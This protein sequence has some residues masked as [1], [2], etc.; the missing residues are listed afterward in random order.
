MSHALRVT[1][2]TAAVVVATALAAPTAL[3]QSESYP[4]PYR[5][6]PNH[7]KMPEGRKLGGTAGID[8]DRDGRSIWAFERCATTTCKGSNV[9]PLLK[10]D[11]SGNVVKSLGAGMFVQP[12]GVY[13][14]AD[15][16][17][18]VTDGDGMPGKGHQVFKLNQDGKVLLT[19]GRAGVAGTGPDTFNRPSDV[20][21]GR[22][23]DIFV[24]DGHGGDSNARI[25][26]FTR[27]GKFIKTWGRKGTGRGE[28]DTPH[29]LAIDAQGRLF[30]GDRGN[31]RIQ[32]FD[33]DGNYLDEWRQFG[34]PSGVFID[35]N[36]MLYVADHQSDE[37]TNP[38]GWKK[39]IRVGTAKDGRVTAF[40][41]DP[42][43]MGSQEGVTVDAAGN[44]YGSLTGGQALKKYTK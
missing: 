19:L 22:N 41:I 34:R 5:E 18:W 36:D 32:I 11:A 20:I 35:K 33:Q 40:I 15:G 2:G 1:L 17:V 43:P 6:L 21:V 9:A 16:N 23:G 29:A 25:V 42:D 26:K 7:F 4:N 14:D 38:G 27:D 13:V 24:A 37:K 3:M 44:I 31:N 8:V 12:H 28:F 10:F 30:V 39:G